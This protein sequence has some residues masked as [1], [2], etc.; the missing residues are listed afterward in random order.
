M[1]DSLNET[2]GVNVKGLTVPEQRISECLDSLLKIEDL[3]CKFETKLNP[4]I[5]PMNEVP[6]IS[7]DLQEVKKQSI[8][9][10]RFDAL[11]RKINQINVNLTN[12]MDRV[13]F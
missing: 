9:Q 11:D 10:D 8:L 4:I 6:G 2:S 13:D 5:V 12:L 7:K 1:V 3:I